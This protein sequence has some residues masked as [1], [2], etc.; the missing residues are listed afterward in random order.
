[1]KHRHVMTILAAIGLATIAVAAVPAATQVAGADPMPPACAPPY[2]DGTV[3]NL[4]H[5]SCFW[6]HPGDI[7]RLE[8]DNSRYGRPDET[9]AWASASYNYGEV[10]WTYFDRYG[11]ATSGYF[12]GSVTSGQTLQELTRSP[13]VLLSLPG[14]A[15][16]EG[17]ADP[18]GTHGGCHGTLCHF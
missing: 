4:V 13:S 16:G 10:D 9:E 17:G 12:Y 14:D 2:L 7:V 8:L 11:L 1:M 6:I 15:T 3:P 5:V 18:G